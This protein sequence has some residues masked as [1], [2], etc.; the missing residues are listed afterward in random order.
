MDSLHVLQ[1]KKTNAGDRI[2]DLQ[3]QLDGLLFTTRRERRSIVATIIERPDDAFGRNRHTTAFVLGRAFQA[4]LTT[5]WLHTT[6]KLFTFECAPSESS[7]ALGLAR[8]ASKATRI[9]AAKQY[10]AQPNADGDDDAWDAAAACV[11]LI[12]ILKEE[13]YAD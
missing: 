4:F 11:R 1:S 2:L 3:Q 10:F 13:R 6:N 7:A 8:N 9:A 5:L 12:A